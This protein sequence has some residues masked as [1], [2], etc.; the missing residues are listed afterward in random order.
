MSKSAPVI[1]ALIGPTAVGK[2]ELSIGLAERMDGEI[3]SADSR[4]IYRQL[5]I[6]TA[7]PDHKH[8]QRVP[9]HFID[10]LDISEP[11]SAG[12]FAQAATER[13]D[14]ILK[15][16]KIPI[17]VGG[18]TLY[19]EALLHGL[20]EIPPTTTA[21]RTALMDRLDREGED[22]LFQE[23]QAVDPDS[24]AMMDAT[25]TQRVVRALEVYIDTGQPL[26]SYHE[27][28]TVS[29]HRFAP[30]VLTR[31]RVELYDRINRRVDEMLDRGLVE[32]NRSLQPYVNERTPNPLRT[33]GYRE[34]LAYLRGEIGFE[35][36]VRLIKRN[37]RRY[38]KRQ[39]TW[40]RRHGE[41]VWFDI[42][43]GNAMDDISAETL[44]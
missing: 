9:H 19:I 5:S 10:E 7:K 30:R 28:K 42:S 20:A 43:Q 3:V 29:R 31:P 38:A 35:E 24:A 34:P 17:V 2:T 37:S 27:E 22:I 40:F 26:S 36:M 25:K 44:Q 23:L 21:T 1:P 15:R 39:L 16:G 6:G 33:I 41:Y 8:L 14:Q 4:Q 12:R 13:I 18:S 32:E 11:F